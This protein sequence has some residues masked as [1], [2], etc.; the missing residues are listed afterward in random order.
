MKE[1]NAVLMEDKDLE[2]VAGGEDHPMDMTVIVVDRRPGGEVYQ[3]VKVS[4]KWN[5][6]SLK[7]VVS[8]LLNWDFNSFDLYR[9]DGTRVNYSLSIEDNGIGQGSVVDA[10]PR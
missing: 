5:V 7:R 9:Y 1:R 3:G 10:C 4:S 6:T 8:R 2:Q